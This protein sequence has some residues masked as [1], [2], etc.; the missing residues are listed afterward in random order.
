MLEKAVK[1]LEQELRKL[2]PPTHQDF[3]KQNNSPTKP[4]KKV[5]KPII[6]ENI[7]PVLEEIDV[8]YGATKEYEELDINDEKVKDRW[9]R[10]IGAMG[11]EAVTKQS[12]ASIVLLGLGAVGVETAKNIV[13]SG[14]KELAIWDDK[15]VKYSDLSGQF[16][17]G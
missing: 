7:E 11:V 1:E 16:F 8:S 14:C 4:K 3:K 2:P 12:K 10:Y 6:E 9:S 5:Q 13:L 15:L 17:L